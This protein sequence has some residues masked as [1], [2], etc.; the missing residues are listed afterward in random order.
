VLDPGQLRRL[1]EELIY[2]ADP[3]RAEERERKRFERRH[4]SFGLTLDHAGTLSGACGDT[5]SAE[6]IKTA[7]H[8]FGPPLGTEDTRTAA[9]RRMD[10]L[11][12]ACQAA[13]DSGTA[14][15]RHGAA[16]HL[17]IMVDE[18]TLAHRTG[19]T[20]TGP[21]SPA[22]T[23][24]TGTGTT[25]TDAAGT[26]AT[27]PAGSCTTAP[28]TGQPAGTSRTTRPS[29]PGTSPD[30]TSHTTRTS[31]DGTSPDGTS[32][33][34]TPCTCTSGTPAASD[35]TAPGGMGGTGG[36][37]AAWPGPPPARTGYGAMLTARQVLALACRAD[38][39]VIRWSDGIPRDV[40]RR[41]RTETPAIR[42]ALEARDQGCRFTGCGMPAVWTTAHH[43][44]PWSE[45]GTTSLN[46]TALLCFVHHHYYIHL[47]G[48]TITGN[49]NTTLRFTHPSKYL[50]LDSPLP[51]Q[52]KPRAP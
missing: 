30:R 3:D 14:G 12:A 18:Q 13:L 11:T 25:G 38:L 34:G 35:P 26:D 33:P 52:T 44:R 10:G 37:P 16:P 32:T 27:G 22:G 17:S 51:S 50:T 7:V 36:P 21:T 46:D 1:G 15:T 9:Q 23:T 49:P 5:L 43:L 47:L 6:I 24:A 2:R 40:G 45:G 4:L 39:S 28:Q 29:P 8:A 19:T 20:G 41:Y 31:P 42:R 48:W